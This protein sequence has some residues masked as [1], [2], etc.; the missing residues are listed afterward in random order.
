MSEHPKIFVNL[1]VKSLD[2]AVAFYTQL[3]YTFD[4]KF[5]DENATCMIVGENIYVMLLVEPFFQS[6]TKKS[7]C[8]TSKSVEALLGLSAE[9]R[10]KVDELVEKAVAAGA[11]TP[12]DPMDY[13]FM[14]Q[15]SYEDL[16]GHTWE[17]FYMD[18]N[19]DMDAAPQQ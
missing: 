1:A 8:D 16:D 7:I 3:G 18:P 5:T 10:E 9:S 12:K 13:G 19:A 17:I 2:R 4:A 14:Y 15:R 6:F 11:V